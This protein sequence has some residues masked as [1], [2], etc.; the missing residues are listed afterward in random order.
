MSKKHR[1]RSPDFLCFVIVCSFVFNVVCFRVILFQ[2]E[3]D[4]FL[5]ISSDI[6][7]PTRNRYL[8][9]L[10]ATQGIGLSGES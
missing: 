6:R 3:T 8:V 2:R 9:T 4:I 10:L 1:V 7:G 5:R